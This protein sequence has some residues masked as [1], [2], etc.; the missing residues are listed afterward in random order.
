MIPRR[1]LG[2]TGPKIS[3]IGVGLWQAGSIYWHGN[4]PD[5]LEEVRRGI[6]RALELGI[7][8]FDTAEIYGKGVSERLLGETLRQSG[9]RS[10]AIIA[11]KVAGFRWTRHDIIKAV[12]RSA[13]RLGTHIDLIQHHWPPPVYAP[14]CRVVRSL[15]EAIER[16]LASYIGLSNYPT[17]L[18]EKA[19]YCLKKYDIVSNQVQYSLAYRK[20]ETGLKPFMEKHGITL[21]AWSPLAKGALAGAKPDTLSRKLD[22]VFRKAAQDR[23]LQETLER[24]AEKHKA[25]K[26]EVALAWLIAKRAVPI[27]GFRRAHRIDS[28]ARAATLKL[29]QED[30][31][32]L[33]EASTGYTDGEYDSLRLNRFI[34]GLLQ[35]LAL[36]LGA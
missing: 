29:P 26:A 5:T 6:L 25:S 3:V 27:P 17:K 24:I 4:T 12:K 36:I 15:E 18:L 34:P 14:L 33:D 2:R 23:R 1:S 10:N 32:A 21:I 13:E 9:L 20:P 11:T 16:G 19:L 8:F 22:P 7:N 31:N 35:R 28:I 30:I